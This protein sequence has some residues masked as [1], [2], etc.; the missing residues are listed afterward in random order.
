MVVIDTYNTNK[1]IVISHFDYE[2]QLKSEL[3]HVLEYDVGVLHSE[4]KGS[5]NDK[6]TRLRPLYFIP[7]KPDTA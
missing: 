1:A 6:L 2:H 7:R 4:N 5:L 3:M